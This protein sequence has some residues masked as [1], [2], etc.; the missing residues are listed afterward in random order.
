MLGSANLVAFA[1]SADLDRSRAFYEERLGLPLARADARAC[2]FDCGGTALRVTLV[3]TVVA[4]P[5][6]VLG[7]SVADIGLAVRSLAELGVEFAR[8]P[9]LEQDDLGIWH[10]PSGALVAWFHDPD[11]NTLSLTQLSS[12]EKSPE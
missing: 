5:Y 2:V 11:G 10:A 1:G 12:E 9:A 6:T 4:A 8:Y 3:G 7:W